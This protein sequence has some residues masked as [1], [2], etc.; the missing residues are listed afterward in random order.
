MT[1]LFKYSISETDCLKE[2]KIFVFDALSTSLLGE[3]Q[4]PNTVYTQVAVW[5]VQLGKSCHLQTI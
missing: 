1:D 5:L 4:S 3:N 2:N